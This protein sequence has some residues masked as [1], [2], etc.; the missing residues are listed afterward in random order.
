VLNRRGKARQP[1]VD[2][3]GGQLRGENE[4]GIR[5]FGYLLARI[6]LLLVLVVFAAN[7]FLDRPHVDALLFAIALAVGI[8]PE[9]LP[10]IISVTLA[11]GAREMAH[12]G[13]IVRRLN[14]IE[15][16]GSMDV[17]CSDKTGTLTE[18]TIRL[19]SARDAQGADAPHVLAAWWRTG[20]AR[21]S[22]P[23][24]R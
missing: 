16:F 23:R 22:S 19:E 8:S 13:V 14:A 10:A 2:E 15:N 6:I 7:V 3:A 17:L 20:I 24:A 9:L 12:R 5:R 1:E 4:R 18:G 11:R 21:V